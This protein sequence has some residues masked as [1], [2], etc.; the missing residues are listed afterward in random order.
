MV[1]VQRV[2]KDCLNGVYCEINNIECTMA[3]KQKPSGVEPKQAMAKQPGA[4]APAAVVGHSELKE[5]SFWYRFRLHYGLIA[6]LAVVLYGNTVV[7]TFVLDDGIVIV[8]NKFTQKG[9]AG[10]PE[11]LRY[12]TFMGA[13]GKDKQLVAGGRYRPLSLV[14][15]A[16][17]WQLFATAKKT[18]AGKPIKDR[19][20]N[21]VYAGSPLAG[22]VG[23]IVLYGLTGVLLYMVLLML[24]GGGT[25]RSTFSVT[26]IAVSMGAILLWMVHPT[27]TEAVANIK[28][29]DEIMSLLFSL[30]AFYYA[31]KTYYNGRTKDLYLV[32][33]MLFL[34]LMSKENAIT[35]VPLIPL[36]LYLF[37]KAPSHASIPKISGALLL[38]SVVFIAIRTAVLGL[39]YETSSTELMN[40]PFYTMTMGQKYA[41]ITYTLI[42]YLV[43]L[44]A[45]IQLT[46][47][48][49][50]WHIPKMNWSDPMVLLS[51]L[52]NGALLVYALRNVWKK[53]L[54]AYGILFYF[55][56]FS[57]M[58]N[59]VFPIGT[60]MGERFLFMPTIGWAL[61]VAVLAA[62][63]LLKNETQVRPFFL[64][65]GL[66][67]VLFTVRTII[68][69][70]AWH[71]NY[72]LVT[73]DL[74]TSSKSAKIQNFAGGEFVYQSSLVEDQAK[75]NE[76]FD[77]AMYHY[78]EA[79]KLHPTYTG[80]F[81]GI[82]NIYNLTNRYPEALKSYDKVLELQPGYAPATTNKGIT[83]RDWGK[84]LGEKK[85]DFAGAE[86][87]LKIAQQYDPKDQET[88]RLLG[89]VYG[90]K[91]DYQHSIEV[92]ESL[93][94]LYPDN[95]SA[96]QNL[97]V[98]Y[99][100]IGET[101]KAEQYRNK[102]YELDPSLRNPK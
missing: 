49:Y 59:I 55:I 72:N 12:D 9:I 27:H 66:V 77:K 95:S 100:A 22:H 4:V 90:S 71:S 79:L 84:Y 101:A 91:G 20:G 67:G 69:N 21:I 24:L 6:L 76:W 30:A 47:D 31:L 11:I 56:T 86:E 16:L 51:L 78:Q 38:A 64:L 81:L 96:L 44:F 57:L 42:R 5:V 18:E 92:L 34:G 65:V 61:A 80:P 54:I 23:N 29:R 45:P 63:F 15:F 17:E 43:L 62:R 68:R 7:G 10:I 3:K 83:Y 33:G 39:S 73:A 87:K 35:F 70:P 19:D 28:G 93:L 52:V 102:A 37:G 8:D 97:A 82:G 25:D 94:K 14:T 46:H 50:P 1:D 99:A 74:K 88:L 98:S 36:A 32:F 13:L 41:T 58:S 85:Q 26:T 75:K 60:F 48:Y 2:C 89:I 40:N 53:D